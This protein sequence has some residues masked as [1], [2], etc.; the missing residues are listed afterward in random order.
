M[1]NKMGSLVATRVSDILL[2]YPTYC[3]FSKVH[4]LATKLIYRVHF[5]DEF[6]VLDVVRLSR[7]MFLLGNTF[8]VVDISN[9]FLPESPDEIFNQFEQF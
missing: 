4:P 9:Q 6:G 3:A 5:D 1:C 8:I 7:T 2:L